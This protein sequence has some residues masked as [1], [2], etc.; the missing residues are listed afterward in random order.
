M[1]FFLVY[2]VLGLQS[3]E[4]LRVIFF[5][6]FSLSNRWAENK[7]KLITSAYPSH[8]YGDGALWGAT[9][10]WHIHYTEGK[11]DTFYART[12]T[13]CSQATLFHVVSCKAPIHSEH[14]NRRRIL[15]ATGRR[16]ISASSTSAPTFISHFSNSDQR[17]CFC[18]YGRLSSSSKK[19]K[20]RDVKTE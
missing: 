9:G 18:L 14:C 5:I 17:N 11:E 10:K 19:S 12:W 4:L 2:I 1:W 7:V 20:P 13:I 3:F 16:H 15:W 6:F 8:G